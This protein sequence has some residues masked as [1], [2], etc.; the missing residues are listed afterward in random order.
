M[1]RHFPWVTSLP[2]H[3]KPRNEGL[4]APCS[5][6]RNG[7]S[8][9]ANNSSKI[10]QTSVPEPPSVPLGWVCLDS[11]WP[12]QSQF[13]PHWKLGKKLRSEALPCS[14]CQRCWLKLKSTL[15]LSI[16]GEE[17]KAALSFFFPPSKSSFPQH[18][19]QKRSGLCL[20]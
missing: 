16:V 7:G 11:V 14:D 1:C 4:V 19:H 8:E 2:S 10:S 3:K 12:R 17:E 6:C 5:M 9:A 18:S 13:L 15:N 20:F